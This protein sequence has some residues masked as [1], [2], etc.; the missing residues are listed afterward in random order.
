MVSVGLRQCG[1]RVGLGW[2]FRVGFGW[3]RDSL[4]RWFGV[5]LVMVGFGWLRMLKCWVR[6]E[7]RGGFGLVGLGCWFGMGCKH[8]PGSDTS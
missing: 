5:G 3:F 8:Y 1:F 2:V 6:G 4:G 7:L